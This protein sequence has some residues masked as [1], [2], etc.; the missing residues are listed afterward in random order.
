LDPPE[1]TITPAK[2]AK[3]LAGAIKNKDEKTKASQKT[4]VQTT[5]KDEYTK[6]A[7]SSTIQAN[8]VWVHV[9]RETLV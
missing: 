1:T 3:I 6:V 7:I 5:A 8:K 4:A 2:K 9:L